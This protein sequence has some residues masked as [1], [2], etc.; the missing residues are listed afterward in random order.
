MIIPTFKISSIYMG[1][2]RTRFQFTVKSFYFFYLS[3][4]ITYLPA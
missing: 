2:K 4:Y 1:I 3:S